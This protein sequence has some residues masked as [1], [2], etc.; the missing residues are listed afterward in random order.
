MAPHLNPK[1]L[2]FITD[3]KAA[4]KGPVEIHAALERKRTARGI[5]APSLPNLRRVMKGKTYKMTAPA[6]ANRLDAESGHKAGE[7]V[8]WFLEAQPIQPI[9][10]DPETDPETD[11][12]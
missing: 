6:N 10:T 5:S 4:G 12:L 7:L 1:E 11:P 2:D 3:L 8:C 9:R